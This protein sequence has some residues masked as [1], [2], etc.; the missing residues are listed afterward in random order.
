[1]AANESEPKK[2][3]DPNGASDPDGGIFGLPHTV[4]ESRI[5]YIPVPWEVTTSYGGGTSNGPRA[6]LEASR[7][8]DL[9]DLELGNF[10][11]AGLAMIEEP[12]VVR[13]MNREGKRLAKPIIAAGGDVKGNRRLNAALAR[14]NELGAELNT[15][16][17]EATRLQ[18]EAGR[19]PA[20]VG[21]DHSVPFGG[22]EA[23]AALRGRFGILHFDAHSDTRRAF[24]G[25][26]WSHA[27]IMHN[28]L[29]RIP[30]VERVVQVGIRDFCEE[31][32]AYT[33]SQGERVRVFFDETLAATKHAGVSWQRIADDIVAALPE[34]VWVSFDIDGLDPR[35]C[36]HTGT[37]VPGGLDF[38]EAVA[39]IKTLA[40]SGKK[41]IGFDLNEVAPGPD[42]EWDGNV[43]AR[44]LYK[45]SGWCLRSNGLLPSS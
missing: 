6:I 25:F 4:E 19:I 10:W 26:E 17:R 29:E 30:E 13:A 1:M 40:R 15:W 34:Q 3:F 45:M 11:Q 2:S 5:T 12:R 37:P 43:G 28:A 21:G 18:L 39:V 35:F 44:L 32:H 23:A 24:E 9:F 14:V 16:V 33:R 42:D 22:F 38:W 41:I 7:Q 20:I 36:P 31:E 27:S 8:V